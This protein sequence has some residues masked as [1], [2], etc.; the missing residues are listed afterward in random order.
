MA[1]RKLLSQQGSHFDPHST[2]IKPMIE[3]HSSG[4]MIASV[5]SEKTS[6][7]KS[8]MSRIMVIIIIIMNKSPET[9][10]LYETETRKVMVDFKTYA[11]Y[12]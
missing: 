2:A 8:M 10:F 11:L 6:L 7:K 12:R 5:H 4:K 1:H 9:D 3:A